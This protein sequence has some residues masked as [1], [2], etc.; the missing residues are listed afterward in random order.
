VVKKLEQSIGAK[1]RKQFRLI[2][3]E[4]RQQLADINQKIDH[5]IKHYRKYYITS[6]FSR[7]LNHEFKD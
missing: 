4:L 5:V 3:R 2:I 6:D 1:C 7:S